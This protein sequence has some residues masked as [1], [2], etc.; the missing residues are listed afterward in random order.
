MMDYLR[1]YIC[2]LMVLTGIVGFMLG[3]HWM[4][5]GVATFPVLLV[6]DL[7]FG[8]DHARRSITLPHLAD[9]P[10]YLHVILMFVLYGSFAWRLGSGVGT[11]TLAVVGG[12]LSLVWLS[13]VPGVPVVHELMHRH[14]VVPRFFAK[15]G[16]AFF[17]DMNRDVSHLITHHIHFDTPRDSDTAFR[18]ENVFSFMWRA[19]KG[20][21]LDA[22]E[23]EKRR[24][25]VKGKSVWSPQSLVVWGIV[26]ML[27]IAA[28]CGIIGGVAAGLIALLAMVGAKFALEALNFL[29]HYGLV[30]QE[31]VAMEKHHTWNHLS[32]VSRAVGYEITTHIDHH[33][34]GD[35]RFDELVPYPEAPQMPSIF[36]CAFMAVIPPFWTRYSQKRL[37]DWDQT[38]AN[39]AERKLAR[40]AN[41]RAGWPDWL[42]E[43]TEAIPA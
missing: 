31:G 20:S 42:G 6:L 25:S 4:W 8:K 15:I 12:F 34:N 24:M 36:I 19:T 23:T 22:W 27:S 30:R 11:E 21:Y 39:S 17:A 37:R 16:S 14:G 2:T 43:P 7:L 38:F 29:Q 5:A 1:Y 40:E 18:G 32:A 3:S 26:S 13:A 10:L 41:R 35:L 28:G 9:V 33:K